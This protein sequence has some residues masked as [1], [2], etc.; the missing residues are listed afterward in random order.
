MNQPILTLNGFDLTLGAA[1]LAFAVAVLALLVAIAVLAARGSRR[2][3]EDTVRQERQD[4]AM[5][6]RIADLAR[7]Q[8]ETA[9]R[10]QALGEGLGGRQ[11][12]PG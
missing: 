11:A 9:G 5:E 4:E 6:K 12:E 7:I 1:G 8:A 10:L 2:R 3:R